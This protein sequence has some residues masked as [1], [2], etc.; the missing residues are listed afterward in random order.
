NG[1]EGYACYR[2]PS[3]VRAINSDLI[4]FAEGRVERC[5]DST[6]VI[7][8]VCKRSTDNG[9][10]WGP[11]QIVAQNIINGEEFACTNCCPVVDTLRGTGRIVALFRKTEHSEWDV[12]KRIG[13]NRAFCIFSDDNGQTW[14]S[15]RDITSM[16]HHPYNPDYLDVYPQAA[17]A[18]NADFDWR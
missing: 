3:I 2:I 4:A 5:S 11:V 10:T 6:K 9:Q 18:V 7:R 12:T 8:I 13:V 15:E 17:E 14:H 1:T 16:V